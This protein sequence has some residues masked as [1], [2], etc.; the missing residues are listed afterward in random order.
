M[1][2]FNIYLVLRGEGR[3]EVERE[4]RGEGDTEC[5]AGSRL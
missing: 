1:F 3:G 5:K 2:V 4:R